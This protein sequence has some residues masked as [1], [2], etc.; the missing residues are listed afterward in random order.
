[1]N[2]A[3]QARRDAAWRAL[4]PQQRVDLERDREMTDP[5]LADYYRGLQE[6]PADPTTEK[7]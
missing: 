3:T 7:D 4:T 6:K 5:Y 2:R 1:M